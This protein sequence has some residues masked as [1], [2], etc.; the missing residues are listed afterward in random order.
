MCDADDPRQPAP[1]E[2]A[3]SS[4]PPGPSP[5]GDRPAWKGPRVTGNLQALRPGGEGTR[6]G[7]PA[8]GAERPGPLRPGSH[9]DQHSCDFKASGG[10]WN[11]VHTPAGG[12]GRRPCPF[13]C[14]LWVVKGW[15]AGGLPPCQPPLP[16]TVSL[17][18]SFIVH[19]YLSPCPC[20]AL[21][22]SPRPC[23]LKLL[24]AFPDLLPLARNVI[25]LAG[26]PRAWPGPSPGQPKGG[27]LPAR[28]SL[29]AR[30]WGAEGLWSSG[31]TVPSRPL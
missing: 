16:P 4:P 29:A 8:G 17:C 25:L 7:L 1:P 20:L 3:S 26:L 28:Q 21:V 23:L 5:C 13:M 14:P 19:S 30:L 9:G 11:I 6:P 15:C 18:L 24:L 10:L 27:T 2:G 31:G 12:Y 22:Q